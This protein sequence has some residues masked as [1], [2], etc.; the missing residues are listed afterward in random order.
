MTRRRRFFVALDVTA[1]L[2]EGFAAEQEARFAACPDASA[3]TDEE[4][5]DFLAAAHYLDSIDLKILIKSLR[6]ARIAYPPDL[7]FDQYRLGRHLLRRWGEPAIRQAFFEHAMS[8]D[9]RFLRQLT[10]P[11]DIPNLLNFSDAF[12]PSTLTLMRRHGMSDSVPALVAAFSPEQAARHRALLLFGKLLLHRYLT[13][14]EPSKQPSRWEQQK[15]ARRL[16]LRD[17]QLRSMQGSRHRLHGERKALLNRLR[18]AS[19]WDYS[20]LDGLAAELEQLRAARAESEQAFAVALTEQAGRYQEALAR[21]HAELASAPQDYRDTL[22]V[23]ST[24]LPL[25]RRE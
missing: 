3:Y 22:S 24:W 6:R 1:S 12:G 25:P 18:E 15:L 5:A 19:R 23:R 16:R 17:V 21:L 11:G 2:D 14:S 10:K 20:E 4:T 7:A 13:E 9:Y 8:I